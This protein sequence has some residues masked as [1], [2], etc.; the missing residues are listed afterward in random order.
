MI[1]YLPVEGN[2]IVAT[3][4]RC[5]FQSVPPLPQPP[6][7]SPSALEDSALPLQWQIQGKPV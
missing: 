1:A 7:Y 2:S 6:T 4:P 3:F 5:P